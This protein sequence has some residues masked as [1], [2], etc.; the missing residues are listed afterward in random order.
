MNRKTSLPIPLVKTILT[1]SIGLV[2]LIN[3]LFCKV[4]NFV[5]RHEAIVARILGEAHA[6]FF[7]KAIGVAEILMF[8]WIVSRIKPRWC[9]ILQI[10]V[11][12]AMNTMEFILVP[13]MLLFGKINSLIALFFIGV[14]F[15]NEFLLGEKQPQI[16]H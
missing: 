10:T 16:S 14:I 4:L 12:A 2:W 6:T 9:A 7:T 3:G 13:D 1:I 15:F 5:P 11:I 8:F